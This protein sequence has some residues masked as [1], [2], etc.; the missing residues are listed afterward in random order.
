MFLAGLSRIYCRGLSPCDA[1]SLA[2]FRIALGLSVAW[3]AYATLTTG[4][5][6]ADYLQPVFHLTYPGLDWVRPWPGNGMNVHF[7]VLLLAAICFALGLLYRTVAVVMCLAVTH[8]FLIE[9]SVYNNHNYLVVLLSLLSTMMPLHR[10]WSIDALGREETVAAT[11]PVWMLWLLRFQI[12]LVYFFG[13]VAK[14]DADWLAGQPMRMW[15]AAKTNAPL[16]GPYASQEWV[17]MVFVWGGLLIDL[18]AVPC[19][20]W[21]RTRALMFAVLMTFHAINSQLFNISFFPWLMM[22]ATAM[23]FTPN[24]P[25]RLLRLEHPAALT[26]PLPRL[27]W[28]LRGR[29]GCSL[30]AGYVIL[31]LTLP[32]RHLAYSGNPSWTEEGQLFAWR[33]MLRQKMTAIRF[34]GTEPATQRG[35]TID[36]RRYLTPRQRAALSRDP[37]LIVQFAHKL[38]E[39]FARNGAPNLEIRVK[40]WVSLNGRQPQLLVDPS[41]DLTKLPR[42]GG[43]SAWIMPL[44]EPYRHDAWNVPVSQWEKI[45]E[46][47]PQRIEITSRPAAALSSIGP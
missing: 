4:S 47:N 14:L 3:F 16:I 28:S 5:L 30:L 22:I 45:L 40:A 10:V 35:G 34:I 24:W 21:R 31:Q 32:L 12:G 7:V 1:A 37:A 8:V 33:M 29:I 2:V 13:G 38:A 39:H 27:A 19:L 23:F 18:L 43:D 9:R 15:L 42:R 17:V 26:S 44:T 41:I 46:Q 11:V 36:I 20:M 6:Q 25:R